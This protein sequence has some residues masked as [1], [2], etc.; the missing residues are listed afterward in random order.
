M[1]LGQF[2]AFQEYELPLRF[3]GGAHPLG[4]NST[5]ATLPAYQ[6]EAEAETPIYKIAEQ[7]ER[8]PTL[9]GVVLREQGQILGVISRQQL[10]EHFLN[11]NVREMLWSEPLRALHQYIKVPSLWLSGDMPILMA[12]QQALN[13]APEYQAEP[14]VVQVVDDYRLLSAAEL[15]VAHWQIKEI[16][17]QVRYERL[18]MQ[19]L[20]SDKMADLGR[21]VDGVAHEILDP[22]SFIWGNLS[23]INTYANQILTLL[24]QYETECPETSEQ[25]TQ[26]RE[27]I[28]IEYIQEDLPLAIKS[29]RGGANRLRHLAIS[30]QNFCH[31][32]EVYPKPANLHGLLDSILLLIQSRIVTP[33][34]IS[35]VYGKLPP[36]PC[37]AG[38]MGQVFMNILVSLIDAL[39]ERE[40]QDSPEL[41]VASGADPSPTI[42]ISTDVRSLN[43]SGANASDANRWVSVVIKD[44]GPGIPPEAEVDLMQIFSAQSRIVKE[45]SLSMSAHIITAK[46]GGKFYVRSQRF[47]QP[48]YQTQQGTEFEILLPIVVTD[49]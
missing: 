43:S 44:N 49:G 48:D 31:I 30:L 10:L 24:Q 5:L 28:E 6:Y 14:I 40:I 8:F 18:Q 35:R 25:L 9:P 15:N 27:E 46:H 16:E 22:V 47:S 1:T 36:I 41:S 17:T 13:R 19:L 3:E 38:Q 33:I 39:L 4:L 26:L 21:L 20:Q 29:V 11:S 7:L 2:P 23:H 45:T 37:F 12:A 42:T 32:D 34:K